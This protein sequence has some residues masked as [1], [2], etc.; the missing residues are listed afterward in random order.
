MHMISPAELLAALAKP[1]R[2]RLL[3]LL[4]RGEACVCELTAALRLPQYQVSRELRALRAAGLLDERPDGKWAYYRLAERL[5][6]T[7][8]QLVDAALALH[9]AQPDATRLRRALC[10]RQDGRCC[11]RVDLIRLPRLTRS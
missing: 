8:R 1:E 10:C 5:P 4:R 9:D 6:A 7:V 3:A 2:L 11:L